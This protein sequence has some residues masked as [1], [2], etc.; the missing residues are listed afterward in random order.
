MK[1]LVDCYKIS[2]QTFLTVFEAMHMYPPIILIDN[3]LV[4]IKSFLI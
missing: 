2:V 1:T 4:N 3:V